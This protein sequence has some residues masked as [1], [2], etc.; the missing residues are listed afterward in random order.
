MSAFSAVV[1]IM[2]D[3]PAALF[4]LG[5]TVCALLL[6]F[7]SY[8]SGP[9][10]FPMADKIVH[11]LLFTF[12]AFMTRNFFG[13]SWKT[14]FCSGIFYGMFS[15]VIQGMFIHGREC[16]MWDAVAD[17]IGCGV[18]IFIFDWIIKRKA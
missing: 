5:H 18:G 2:D 17:C 9:L 10:P 13:T 16:S 3:R 12:L 4:F 15:E 8:T 1:K 7:P 6:Y 11:V 14:F